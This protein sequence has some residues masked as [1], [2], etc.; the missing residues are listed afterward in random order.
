VKLDGK[1][2]Q[3]LD[4]S[5][6][7]IRDRSVEIEEDIAGWGLQ[8]ASGPR[9]AP[10]ALRTNRAKRLTRDL[11]FMSEKLSGTT[12]IGEPFVSQ[13]ASNRENLLS[14]SLRAVRFAPLCKPL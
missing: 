7:C 4:S 5:G 11:F 12:R 1:L 6:E 2:V 13:R 14:V 3:N 10:S 9:T 8:R